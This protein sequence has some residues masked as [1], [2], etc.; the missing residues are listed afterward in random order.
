MLSAM[1]FNIILEVLQ[2]Q[3]NKKKIKCIKIGKEEVKLPLFVGNVTLLQKISKNE[4]E[5]SIRPNKLSKV[6]GYK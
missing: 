6:V 3:L 2:E 1:L 4:Q 5:K